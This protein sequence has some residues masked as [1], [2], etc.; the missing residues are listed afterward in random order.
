MPKK[1]RTT[2]KGNN[3]RSKIGA[4]SKEESSSIALD[5][6]VSRKKKGTEG[7]RKSSIQTLE[8]SL[9]HILSGK[10][11][12]KHN[13][14]KDPL[15]D[16]GYSR[17]F[18]F[19]PLYKSDIFEIPTLLSS[20][21][22]LEIIKA[23]E[24]HGFEHTELKATRWNAYRCNGRT[25]VISK[26]LAKLLWEQRL[27]GLFPDVSGRTAIGLNPNFRLYK[28]SPQQAFGEHI[29]ES[30]E[31]PAYGQGVRT[32]F[33]LLV[34]LNGD[35]GGGGKKGGRKQASKGLNCLSGGETV[36]YKGTKPGAGKV[37][38]SYPPTVG[39]ALAHIHGERCMLH[40]GAEVTKGVKYLL[41][42]DVCY[43]QLR[44]VSEN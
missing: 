18:L 41:R 39:N 2:T 37:A 10:Q 13:P 34:Y 3:G 15:F 8:T 24:S 9:I 35:G 12:T 29:D 1:R 11:S 17:R 22:C 19:R 25:Q 5:R 7:D 23:A 30:N 43:R 31:V 38:L 20:E 32:L 44:S 42:T 16:D 6:N 4:T 14:S 21:E 40:E 27:H 36:F 33:T 26:A 28:Y